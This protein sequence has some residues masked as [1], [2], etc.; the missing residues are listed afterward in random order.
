MNNY[1]CLPTNFFR[2]AF[3]LIK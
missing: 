2:Y 3:A 1:S